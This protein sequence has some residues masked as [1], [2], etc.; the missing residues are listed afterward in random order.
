MS[1][2]LPRCSRLAGAE[3]AGAAKQAAEIMRIET[4]LAKAS[5]DVTSRRD[6]KALVHR[7]SLAEVTSQ[8]PVVFVCRLFCRVHAP[9]FT[10]LNV[11]VPAFQK[12]LN[13]L[14]LNESMANIKSY[15]TWHYVSASGRLLSSPFVNENFEFYS[16]T[17]TGAS[18]LR[19][20]WKRC[21][22]STD[23][24]LGEALGQLFVERTHR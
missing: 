6:P 17:L 23:D 10:T 11:A 24:E 13:D 19:P 7:E 8:S 12:A 16:R 2:T 18:Q 21:V 22:A 14:L 3:A 1:R 4:A 5:L 9:Q 20:R 15:L